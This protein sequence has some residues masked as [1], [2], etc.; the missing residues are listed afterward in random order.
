MAHLRA[1][2]LTPLGAA[3]HPRCPM[4][5]L[6]DQ[7]VPLED[8]LGPEVERL[9]ERLFEAPDWE[10]RLTLAEVFLAARLEDARAEARRRQGT[11][12]PRGDRRPDSR[13][14]ARRRAPLQPEAPARPVPRACRAGAEDGRSASPL[15]PP[16]PPRRTRTG[17]DRGGL[18]GLCGY[19]DQSHL[20]REVRRSP[21]AHGRAGA[22]SA[23]HLRPRRARGVG[24]ASTRPTKGA[25]WQ[26]QACRFRLRRRLRGDRLARASVR[27]RERRG[28]ADGQRHGRPRRALVRPEQCDAGSAGGQRGSDGVYVVVEDIDAH[29]ERAKAA[30]AEIVR[31]LHD[32][33]YGSR[34]YMARDPEGRL[35]AFGTYQASHSS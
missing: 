10:T 34:D 15:Q 28:H 31:D 17:P 2:D 22:S 12:A 8:L 9:E 29:Y 20:T 7:V 3:F 1:G 4:H 18:A 5:E 30:G 27:L 23:G 16:P 11:A 21:A 14:G 13:R 25:R 35:W 26:P 33:D 32:T 24:L 19:Y 6:E